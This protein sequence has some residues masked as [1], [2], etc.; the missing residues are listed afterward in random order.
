MRRSRPDADR[1]ERIPADAR[2]ILERGEDAPDRCTIYDASIPGRI[3]TTW[4]TA[5]DGSFVDLEDA[6]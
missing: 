3:E 1:D 5:A 2:A 4:I 6:R